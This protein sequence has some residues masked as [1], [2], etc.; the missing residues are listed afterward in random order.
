MA[1]F[2]PQDFGL[3]EPPPRPTTPPVR[4]GFLLVLLVLCLAAALVYGLPVRGR[5]DG[6]R[7]GVGPVA[8]GDRDPGEAGKGGRRQPRQRAVPDRDRR[9][10]A[11]RREHPDPE[12]PPRERRARPPR[13]G[14]QPVRPGRWRASAS[15]RA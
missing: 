11:G 6:L 12:V 7:L 13:R 9:R 1:S 3:D 14:G 4:R 8:G 5:A 2:H 10:L 15:A